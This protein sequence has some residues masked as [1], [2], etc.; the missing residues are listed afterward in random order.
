MNI[1]ELEKVFKSRNIVVLSIS[2]EELRD[3]LVL[4]AQFLD[5]DFNKICYV[6]FSKP[7]GTLVDAFKKAGL[8]E[9]K[10]F[11]IDTLTSTVTTPKEVSN[12]LFIESPSDLTSIKLSI[13][14]AVKMGCEIVFV[15][16][17]TTLLVY[18][19]PEDVVK[20]S[21]SLLTKIR[22]DGKKALLVTLKE[23]E[24]NELVKGLYEFADE[25]IK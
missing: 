5:K 7:Y 17:F 23:D 4:A 24:K 22:V 15:D 19:S 13:S 16:S 6:S 20:F 11:F 14:E 3:V 25:V 10:F 9:S 8:K 1:G 2:K 21:N 12:C 18:N